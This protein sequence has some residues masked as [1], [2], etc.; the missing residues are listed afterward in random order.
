MTTTVAPAPTTTVA[1]KPSCPS[2]LPAFSNVRFETSIGALTAEGRDTLT[3]IANT[4]KSNPICKIVV[5]GHTDRR[6]TTESNQRLSEARAASVVEFLI[7]NGVPADN[8]T[9][10]GKGL[11]EPLPGVDQN[12][13]EGLALNRRIEFKQINKGS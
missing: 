10:E 4:L 8:L 2:T 6:G 9:S 13:D 1:P 5:V 12:T 7:A 3:A 11:T